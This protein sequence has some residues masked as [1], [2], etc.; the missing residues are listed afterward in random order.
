MKQ[1]KSL[2]EL[3]L[4][5]RFLF[6]EVV[7]DKE[8]MELILEIIL[9]REVLLKCL[10]QSEKETRKSPL[11]RHIRLDVWAQDINEAVYNTEVQVKNTGNLP[12]R[13]RY[14]QSLID[15]KMLDPGEI[16]FN[17]LNQAYIIIISPFDL[18]GK[19]KYKYTFR[20]KC[21][22]DSD[23]ALNDGAVRIFLNTHGKN[24]DEI[25]PELLQLLKY[26]ENT[27]AE[28]PNELVSDKIKALK[29]RVESI[30]SS[31][32]VSVKYMQAWEEHIYDRREGR[33]E[34]KSSEI[35]IIRKKLEKA[36]S[37][38]EIA[39]WLEVEEEYIAKIEKLIC[40]YPEETDVQIAERYF[41][42]ERWRADA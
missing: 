14:Y 30:R 3:T 32:E 40:D 11:Y 25:S 37:S 19:G 18:F 36:M 10:P 12:K 6:D 9:G 15:S 29:K 1:K 38:E 34:G 35:R 7:E 28:I 39:D 26:M 13:S 8:S 5:D 42:G 33:A 2:K 16:D 4:L 23:V 31:E 41:D 22:E 27:N 24:Q 20:M 17:H 21:D